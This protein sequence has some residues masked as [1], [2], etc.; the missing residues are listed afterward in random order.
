MI[1]RFTAPSKRPSV[2]EA[3][4][5]VR[6]FDDFELRLG[7]VMRGERATLGKSLLDVQRELKIKASYISAIENADPSAF[8]TPGFVA[9]YV[10]SPTRA[11]WGWTR[12]GRFP[13]SAR[14][15][16]LPSRMGCRRPRP[17]RKR[18]RSDGPKPVGYGRDPFVQP[19]T[20]FVPRAESPL[21]KIEPGMSLNPSAPGATS[22]AARSRQIMWAR[23]RGR[24]RADQ[25]ADHDQHADH[26][27]QGHH[28]AGAGLRRG[29][30]RYRAR[31]GA[32]T[33]QSPRAEGDRARK[34][35]AH[36]GGHPFPLQAR[37]RGRRGGRGLPAHQPR[38][39]R[40]RAT[41]CARSSRPRATTAVRC[42]SA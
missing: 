5:D 18:R 41:A 15:A 25:R 38:Q 30:R 4:D 12:N 17:A 9:G 1:G 6:G 39:Y 20:P 24:R 21:S 33:R 19:S 37:D 40:R 29:R 35:G 10:R 27:C 23:A 31:L 22:T 13:S 8:E 2:E 11:I 7:D 36:R 14:K 3:D 42:A 16:A 34:P 32:R 28:R 26:R